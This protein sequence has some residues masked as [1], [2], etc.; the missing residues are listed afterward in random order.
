MVMVMVM[1]C[2]GCEEGIE[3]KEVVVVVVVIVEG[4]GEEEEE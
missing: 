3:E 1:G 2:T 4:E